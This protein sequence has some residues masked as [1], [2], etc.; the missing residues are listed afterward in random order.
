M[1]TSGP[2]AFAPVLREVERDLTLPIPAR[3]RILRELQ[4]DLEELMDRFVD[5]GHPPDRARTMALEAL[6]PDPETIKTLGELHSPLYRRITRRM[7]THRVRFVERSVLVCST[8]TVLVLQ[9]MTLFQADLLRR[10][11][12]FLIPVLLAG[13]GLFALVVWKAFRFWIK[14]DHLNPG[15][16]LSVILAASCVSLSLGIIGIVFDFYWLAVILERSPELAGILVADWL[17]RDAALLSVAILIALM[18]GLAW[19]VMSQWLAW[20]SG[21]RHELLGSGPMAH[22]GE[23]GEHHG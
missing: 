10:P 19:F 11:S 16:G 21:A 17:V 6:V 1:T 8:L 3:V 23:G 5:D 18:G 13:A 15:S 14:K 12:P 2:G 20:V 9:G 4:A 22:P 7:S